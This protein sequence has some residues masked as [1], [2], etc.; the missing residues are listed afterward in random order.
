[1]V[2]LLRNI[3]CNKTLGLN[4]YTDINDAPL[5]DLLRKDIIKTNNALMALSDSS[6]QYF[7]DT[8]R[9]TGSY[10]IFYQCRPIDH[11]TNVPGSVA[12]SSS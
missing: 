4:Y 6:W 9:S 12:Q 10:I 1:M 11:G 2:H 7:P 3:R 8:G 5:S